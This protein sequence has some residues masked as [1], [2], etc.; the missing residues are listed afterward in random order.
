MRA[1]NGEKEVNEMNVTLRYAAWAL[2]T[3]LYVVPSNVNN[4]KAVMDIMDYF[5]FKSSTVEIVGTL[6]NFVSGA[7]MTSFFA[8][9]FLG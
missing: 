5:K 3:V 2:I 6:Y 1:A 9:V 8:W 4:T 7:C